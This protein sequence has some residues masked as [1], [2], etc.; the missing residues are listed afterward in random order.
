MREF[1]YGTDQQYNLLK[2][3]LN[4]HMCHVY[5]CV[6]PSGCSKKSCRIG[7][8]KERNTY[9]LFIDKGIICSRSNTANFKEWLSIG[10]MRFLEFTDMKEFLRNLK[11][12]YK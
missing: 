9:A 11:S 5:R 10:T 6:L 1:V 7:F 12:L 3:S 8:E 4:D 2:E